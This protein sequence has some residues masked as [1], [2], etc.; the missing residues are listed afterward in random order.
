[1]AIGEDI[2]EVDGMESVNPKMD[3]LLKPFECGGVRPVVTVQVTM[4]AGSADA[5]G[6]VAVAAAADETVS[7]FNLLLSL[8]SNTS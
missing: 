4:A 3:P 8:S 6:A 5:A 7:F 2:K 1:M